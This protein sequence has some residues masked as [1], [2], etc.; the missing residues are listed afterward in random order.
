MASLSHHLNIL[1]GPRSLILNDWFQQVNGISYFYRQSI[2][3]VHSVDLWT[4]M[5]VNLQTYQVD[6]NEKHVK[7][8]QNRRKWHIDILNGC[9]SYK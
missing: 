3:Y 1:Y 8:K 9:T 6:N 5:S 7:N 2:K 4:Y